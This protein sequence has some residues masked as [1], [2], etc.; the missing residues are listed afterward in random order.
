MLRIMFLFRLWLGGTMKRVID[1][2]LRSVQRK[3]YSLVVVLP[4]EWVKYNDIHQKDRLRLKG[5]QDGNLIIC[6]EAEKYAN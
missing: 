4:H 6:P 2:G 1:L 3:S 5:D